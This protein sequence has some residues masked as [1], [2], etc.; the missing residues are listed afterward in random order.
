MITRPLDLAARLR[1]PPRS[2]DAMFYVNVGAL[3]LVFALY[4]SRFVLSPGLPLTFALPVTPAA[5]ARFAPVDLV[6]AVPSADVAYA[7]GEVLDFPGLRKW[8][9][10]RGGAQPGA[11]L[12][13]QAAATLPAAA[14]AQIQGYAAEAGLGGVLLATEASKVE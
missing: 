7:G 12:L 14:I 6:V 5:A 8:L 11:R 13:V 1:R 10:E 2:L 9:R 3:V 4:G